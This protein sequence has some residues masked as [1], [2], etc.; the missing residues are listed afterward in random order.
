MNILIIGSGGREHAIAWSLYYASSDRNIFI[1]SDNMNK[2]GI[3]EI[4]TLININVN[5]HEEVICFCKDNNIDFVIVGVEIP[6]INGIAD[7]LELA[8]IDVFGPNQDA[9]QLEGSKDFT[10][11]IC[12]KY[13]IPTAKYKTFTDASP[14]IE[15]INNN[16]LPIVIKADGPA[17]GK[18]VVIAHNIEEAVKAVHNCLTDNK[19]GSSG[20]SVVIEEFLEGKEISFF[21]ISDGN[22]VLPIGSAQDYKTIGE[23]GKGLNTGGMGAYSPSILVNEETE[24]EIM[25]EIIIPTLNGLLMEDIVFKGILF[26]GLIMT[27]QG[28]KL[29]EYNVR[30]GDPE[31]QVI[32]PRIEGDLFPLLYAA[33]TGSL[34]GQTIN[35]KDESAVCIVMA[36]PGYPEEYDKNSKIEGLENVKDKE[37]IIIF[38]AGTEINSEGNIIATGGRVL[39][40]TAICKELKEARKKA[41]ETLEI[42]KW[43]EGV[44]RKDIASI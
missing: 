42:I 21:A 16:S 24:K 3:S 4:A 1:T 7:S 8:G 17:A 29:L 22:S 19:F 40:I 12:T 34:S 33:S 32:I 31:A 9:A 26:A 11:K 18:G 30:F 14:A 37:N 13:N 28:I 20:S 6:L 10:K 25:E 43:P 44:Y 39:G 41:Y 36:N 23:F 2:G 27:K 35:I 38:H 5:D 15:Y